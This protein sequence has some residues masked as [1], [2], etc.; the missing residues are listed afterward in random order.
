M[1]GAG[2]VEAIATLHAL[3][4]GI[5]PPTLGLT[6]P[7]DGL[8]LDYAP[9]VARPMPERPGRGRVAISNSFGLGGNNAVVA[10]RVG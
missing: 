3:R 8:D 6:D 5:A 10:L 1:G 7:D 9:G 2:T 4:D